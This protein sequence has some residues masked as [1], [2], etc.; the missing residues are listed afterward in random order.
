[1]KARYIYGRLVMTVAV[2]FAASLM[3]VACNEDERGRI[4]SYEKG[5]YLG[6]ADTPLSPEQLNAI[7]NRH[8]AMASGITAGGG[9]TTKAPERRKSAKASTDNGIDVDQLRARARQQGG[10]TGN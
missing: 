10:G 9:S 3:L 6:K 1:M 7:K 4:T 2:I 5:Q 8:S